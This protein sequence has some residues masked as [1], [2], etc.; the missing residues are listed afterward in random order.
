VLILAVPSL[1]E[2]LLPDSW[3]L[4]GCYGMVVH[5]MYPEAWCPAPPTWTIEALLPSFLL[6]PAVT[7]TV[8]ARVE[9]RGGVKGLCAFLVALWVVSFGP[10]LILY[11]AQG[12]KINQAQFAVQFFWPPAQLID[13]VI[14]VIAAAITQQQTGATCRK[15]AHADDD[16]ESRM[17]PEADSGYRAWVRSFSWAGLLADVTFF[18]VGGIILLMPSPMASLLKGECRT[19]ADALLSHAFVPAIAGF[20]HW[21]TVAGRAGIAAQLLSHRFLVLLSTYS[22]EVYLFQWPVFTAVRYFCGRATMP[23]Q[24]FMASFLA[25]WLAAGLYVERVAPLISLSIVRIRRLMDRWSH[26]ESQQQLM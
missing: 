15:L 22:L 10:I 12:R 19:D 5:W 6:Y 20:L 26:G 18:T 1:R 7:R 24:L 23:S 9:A 16:R 14:G 4:A 8:V 3:T 11:I 25:L 13:F 21:S 2:E 17:L